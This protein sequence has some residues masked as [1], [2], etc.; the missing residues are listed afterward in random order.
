ML[1]VTNVPDLIPKDLYMH[2]IFSQKDR[3]DFHNFIIM[4]KLVRISG[5]LNFKFVDVQ[6]FLRTGNNST[7]LH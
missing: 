1:N 7:L 6:L 5:N 2:I 3:R 4:T